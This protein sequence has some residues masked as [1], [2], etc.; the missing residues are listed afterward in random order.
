M[1]AREAFS[2]R[3]TKPLASAANS[4][5]EGISLMSYLLAP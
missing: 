4:A 1:V 5:F 2:A 3:L